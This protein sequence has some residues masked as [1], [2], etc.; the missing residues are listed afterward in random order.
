[1]GMSRVGEVT[2]IPIEV[3]TVLSGTGLTGLNGWGEAGISVDLASG[4]L[5]SKAETSGGTGARAESAL[6]LVASMAL[7]SRDPDINCVETVEDSDGSV[8]AGHGD[9]P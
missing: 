6:L 2:A 5:P 9:W 4:E 7:E 8:E 1:M 3:S